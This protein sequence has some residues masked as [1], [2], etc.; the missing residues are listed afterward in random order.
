MSTRRPGRPSKLT[1]VVHVRQLDDGSSQQV[2]AADMIVDRLS[3]GAYREEAARSTG[4]G[5]QTLYNWLYAGAQA[6]ARLAKGERLTAQERRH[7]EFLDAVERAEASAIVGDWLT[8]GR[9][10]A[11]G[12]TVT[13]RSTKRDGNGNVVEETVTTETTLPDARVLMWRLERRRPDLFG[14]RSSTGDLDDMPDEG[15]QV[16]DV[17]SRAQQLVAEIDAYRA[18]LSEHPI[19]ASATELHSNGNGKHP[20]ADDADV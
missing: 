11:G 17:R 2:T 3:A 19:E 6:R 13:K 8:L 9:L 15:E 4:V 5:K 14:R 16:E 1:S 7:A 18:G 10:A 12:L 20:P